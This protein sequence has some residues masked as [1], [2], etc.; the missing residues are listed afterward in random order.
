MLLVICYMAFDLHQLVKFENRPAR[1]GDSPTTKN[2]VLWSPDY[3]RKHSRGGKS[4]AAE[5]AQANADGNCVTQPVI[6]GVVHPSSAIASVDHARTQQPPSLA[7]AIR[8]SCGSERSR[9][10]LDVGAAAV[11]AVVENWKSPWPSLTSNSGTPLQ[12]Q[13]RKQS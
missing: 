13:S 5:E 8:R 4:A 2:M 11:R 10:R 6:V 12:E 7:I 9:G 3:Q 1:T